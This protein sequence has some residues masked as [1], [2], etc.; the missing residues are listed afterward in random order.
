M[1]ASNT[2]SSRVD[3][4]LGRPPGRK[5]TASSSGVL[6]LRCWHLGVSFLCALQPASVDDFCWPEPVG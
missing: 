4:A 1:L 3:R 6:T 5:G 2:G